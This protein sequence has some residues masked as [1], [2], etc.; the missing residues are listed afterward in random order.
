MEA[1][2]FDADTGRLDLTPDTPAAGTK[3]RWSAPKLITAVNEQVPEVNV[4]ALHVLTPA[5]LK[6]GPTTTADAAPAPQPAVPVVPVERRPPPEGYRRAVEA[7]RQAARPSRVDPGIA[8]AVERQTKAMRE[9]SRRAFPEPDVAPDDVL[10]P[11]GQARV[12]A[13]S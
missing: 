4:R 1:V 2:A 12:A 5:P 6:T 10:V 11:I 3:L 8:A 7:H 9:L 13:A